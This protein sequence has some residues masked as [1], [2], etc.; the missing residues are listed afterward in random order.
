ME[1]KAA[2]LRT[3]GAPHPYGTTKPLSIETVRLD[4]P[5]AGEVLVKIHAAGLC[6]SDLSNINGWRPPMVPMV[7]G[8]EGAGE[9]VEIGGAVTDMRVGDHVVFQFAASCGRCVH[10]LEGRP[11]IC[12]LAAEA[13]GR[14]ELMGG[15]RRIHDSE[16]VAVAHQAGIS[17]FAEYA[18]VD[19]GSVV[20]IDPGFST[21]TAA[22]FGCAVMTGVGSIMNAARIRPGETVAIVGLG[23]VGMSAV[24]GA[25]IAGAGKIIGLD[26]DIEKLERGKK[27]G[28]THVYDAAAA[29]TA[30]EIIDLTDGGVDYAFE[31]VGVSPALKMAFSLVRR[32]GTMII[33][34]LT[35][36]G[37]GVE[38]DTSAMVRE[39]KTIKGSFMGSCVPVRDLPRLIRM[40]QEGKLGVASLIDTVFG[41]DGL[42]DGF[43]K[44]ES[45]KGLRQLL[46]PAL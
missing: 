13:A 14:G 38:F 30:K 6:H 8:H 1:C 18:V 5:G 44:L 7:L 35:K 32:G 40:E 2:I 22:I 25:K 31:F 16:G 33:G 12:S 10:C 15:G 19:R 43:E 34:G 42:N 46:I 29:D 26:L 3:I 11:Q 37:L 41:F 23:G 39:E 9:V 17:C 24:L 21:Q 45:G 20:V 28:A 4:P 36:P 27:M